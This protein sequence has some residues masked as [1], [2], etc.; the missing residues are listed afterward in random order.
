MR[1]TKIKVPTEHLTEKANRKVS[2]SQVSCETV[3]KASRRSKTR[4]MRAGWLIPPRLA[5]KR[6]FGKIEDISGIGLAIDTANV[7]GSGVAKSF[8]RKI[9]FSK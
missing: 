5:I 7:S 4:A 9:E 3:R 1:K 6:I 8:I 2:A